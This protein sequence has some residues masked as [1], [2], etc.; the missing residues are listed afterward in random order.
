MLRRQETAAS[1]ERSGP[2]PGRARTI[3][4]FTGTRAE[5]GLLKNVMRAVMARRD[6]RLRVMAS[7]AHLSRA[8]GMSLDEIV[9]DGIPVHDAIPIL[10]GADSPLAVCAAMG[11]GLKRYG[12]ALNG[13]RPDVLVLLGD[14]YETF[15]MAAAATACGVPLAHIHGGETTE[16]AFDEAFRHSITKMS[17]LHF[18]SCEKH[19]ERVI[20]LGEDPARVWNAGSLG[21]ENALSRKQPPEEEVRAL[22][23][24]GPEQ[25]YIVC[26]FHPATL[27]DADPERQ[28]RVLL[29]ALEVFSDYA[30]V[31]TGANAD[32]G[33]AAINATLAEYA[34][35]NSKRCRFF[36]SLG[37]RDYLAAVRYAACVCGNSSSGIIEAPSLGVPVVDVGSR[38][39][40]RE[41][42]DSTLHCDVEPE[43]IRSAV[44]RALTE[45]QKRLAET[46]ANPYS[47]AGTAGF[48]AETLARHP[49]EHI[50]KKH[51]YDLDLIS[52]FRRSG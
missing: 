19:R 45:E 9:R 31:F 24:L 7:A 8:H 16:G 52:A 25:L 15:A 33:G 20:Q 29:E 2:T 38:Q 1:A 50:L 5:Y 13:A 4:V 41:R 17:H 42:A 40:G 34:D 36:M 32:P 35:K 44:A 26:T 22:L 10:D 6:C 46:T 43:A 23:R 49:L 3:A 21:V 51:F 27:E 14:R 39:K 12:E 18:T 30:L 47:T 11:D 28:C 48:I 37:S